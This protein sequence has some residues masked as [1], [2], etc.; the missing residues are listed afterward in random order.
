MIDKKIIFLACIMI[1]FSACGLVGG[2]STN[3]P[4]TITQESLRTG[5]D[6]LVMSVV[7]GAP[8]N[9]T[10]EKGSIF[11]FAINAANK[12]ASDINDGKI[13]VSYDDTFL[14]IL[15]DPWTDQSYQ[16]PLGAGNAFKFSLKGKA[17]DNPDGDV[18]VYSKNFKT[19]DLFG[20]TQSQEVKF[21]VSACYDYHTSKGVTI[22]LDPDP[23]KKT[24]KP[25]QMQSVSMASEG[26]P[27]VITRVEPKLIKQSS[28][29]ELDVLV[30][31]QNNGKGQIYQRGKA[32]AACGGSFSG[33]GKD[34]WGNLNEGDVKMS[35]STEGTGQDF[36]CG[37]FPIT[38]SAKESS[39][40]CVYKSP[41]TLTQPYATLLFIDL[42]YGYT[43][44]ISTKMIISRRVPIK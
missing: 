36:D 19:L 21:V 8:P 22:C 23:L 35:L 9:E 37:P 39:F 16:L 4:V 30:Y 29:Y 34:F 42:G 40:R 24:T 28:G 1:I 18:T 6:A 12:G 17:V 13:V 33:L 31:V 15:D 32:A 10:Y 38:I 14:S 2:G 7:K 5:T 25:C 44:A 20:Q 3:K 26:A 43:S 41:I 11:P 27:L